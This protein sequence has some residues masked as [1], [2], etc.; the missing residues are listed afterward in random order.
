MLR[1][2]SCVLFSSL[3]ALSPLSAQEDVAVT[4]QEKAK[5]RSALIE[6][7]EENPEIVIR[8]IQEFQ[9]R[10]Q[11]ASMLPKIDM[12]RGYLESDPSLPVLGNPNG[13]VTIVE[14]FDYRCGY[15]RRHFPELMRLVKE[16]GNIRLIPHQLPLLDRP[17]QTPVSRLAARAAVAAHKQGKFSELHFAMMSTPT[18]LTEDM[19]YSLAEDQGIDVE[20]L[21]K[22]MADKLIDK[23]VGNSVAIARDIGFEG[24]PGYIIGNDVVLGAA[25]FDRMKEAVA[26][27]RAE[28]KKN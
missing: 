5:I 25:G 26:R 2:I 6:I 22:D 28:N 10:S 12:Y 23:T 19:I 1:S 9:R 18:S 16:D 21:K 7:F 17:G 11:V 24:T 4:P 8:A 20:R 15:C 27:A 3:I 14:F 13:D